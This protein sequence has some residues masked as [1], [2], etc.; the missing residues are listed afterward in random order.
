[1]ANERP[2]TDFDDWQSTLA[3]ERI[4]CGPAYPAD[5]N[6]IGNGVGQW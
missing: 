1:M 6:C 4:E 3:N 2:I 5:S